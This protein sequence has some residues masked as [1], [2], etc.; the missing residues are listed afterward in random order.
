MD[1]PYEVADSAHIQR[2]KSLK[3]EETKHVQSA[4][5][6]ESNNSPDR[7]TTMLNGYGSVS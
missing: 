1:D 4:I 6:V 7:L 3:Q 5:K 2:F